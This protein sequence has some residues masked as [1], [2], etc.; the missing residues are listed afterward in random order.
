MGSSTVPSATPT[1]EHSHKVVSFLPVPIYHASVRQ[2]SI[3]PITSVYALVSIEHQ[4]K[5]TAAACVISKDNYSVPAVHG[6]LH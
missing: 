2:G 3:C 1:G 6:K 5:H 4:Y